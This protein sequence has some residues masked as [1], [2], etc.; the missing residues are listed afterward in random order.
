MTTA[1]ILVKY[2]HILSILAMVSFLFAEM[3]LVKPDMTRRQIRYVSRLDAGYGMAALLV[4]GAGLTLWFGVGKGAEFYQNPILHIKVTLA[5]IAGLISIIPTVFYI[6][7]RKGNP[8]EIVSVP[9]R[10][11][12]L[13]LVQ[14]LI[15]A[16]LPPLAIMTAY[17]VRL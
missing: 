17:G 2:L 13:I 9:K 12:R 8:D 15:L 16:L 4:V 7:Q 14:L 10:I 1:F 11:R 6:R 3:I 5:I